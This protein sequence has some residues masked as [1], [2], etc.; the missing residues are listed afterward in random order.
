MME[1]IA[2]VRIPDS[3]TARSATELIFDTT[4]SLIYHHSRRVFLFASL[5]SRW[6]GIDPDP[7]LLYV[8]ALTPRDRF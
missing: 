5:Q 1:T 6:L 4:S 3:R 2:G 7:E 8:A